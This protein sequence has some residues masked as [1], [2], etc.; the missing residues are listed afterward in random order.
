MAAAAVAAM[1]TTSGVVRAEVR[2][3]IVLSL[4]GTGAST[5]LLFKN[6]LTF[7]PREIGGEKIRYYVV[8]SGS[9]PAK[10]A[11]VAR[12][13]ITQDKV[14]ILLGDTTAPAATAMTPVAAELQTLQI[15]EP[16]LSVDP[17]KAD[18]TVQVAPSADLWMDKILEHMQARGIETVGFIGFSDTW[19]DQCYASL[20]R[21]AARYGVTVVADERYARTETSVEAQVDRLL[22]TNPTA[23]FVGT[24]TIIGAMPDVS[25]RKRG[26]RGM[27]YN[28]PG[29]LVPGFAKLGTAVEG[30]V[31]P[32]GPGAYADQLPASHPSRA[33]GLKFI[34]AYEAVYGKG[35]ANTPAGNG[36]DLIHIFSDI[37]ERALQSGIKPGTAA[38]RA[39]VR[40]AA[41]STRELAGVNGVYTFLPGRLS[42]LDERA[43][44]LIQLSGG[45]WKVLR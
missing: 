26:Y 22:H 21:H 38:F 10:A 43:I 5:G 28:T 14:D 42:G 16:P 2:A 39:T 23:V 1:L 25:L 12:R 9:D 11:Q 24:S 34:A 44:V 15:D 7:A 19:G 13:L 33:P 35:S 18:W 4:T 29:I 8:D 30:A 27:I 17:S 32:A 36:A 37:I 41:F 3:G 31:A 20:T 6:V 40:D 45:Q